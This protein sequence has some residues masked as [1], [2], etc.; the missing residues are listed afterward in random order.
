MNA[1]LILTPVF[2]LLGAVLYAEEPELPVGDGLF[3]DLNANLG[4]EVEDGYR[5]RAWRNQVE[6]NK[7]DVFVKQDEGRKVAGSGRPTLEENVEAIGGGGTLIFEEQ[8]LLN[9]NEDAFDHMVTGNGYT[10]FSVMSVQKQNIGKKD[11]NSFFGNLRNGP[12]YE[13]FWGNL[14]DDNRV[15]MGTRNGISEKGKPTLWHEKLNP[16]VSSPEPISEGR[17]YLIMGR[18]G[19]G[20]GVVDLELFVNSELPVDKKQVPVN[21]EAD[22]SKMAIGQER[23]ATNHPGKESFHGAI[24]RFLVYER[25]LKDE[26]LSEM[27][28]FLTEHYKIHKGG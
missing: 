10:W 6:G 11:V 23:D 20:P 15:W 5:V 18:M 24:A 22:P 26:E 2:A 21:P 4:V 28:L 9:M 19:A 3:L 17:Y 13:G 27:I 8:E 16:C 7:A 1:K 25:P 12:P 14:M